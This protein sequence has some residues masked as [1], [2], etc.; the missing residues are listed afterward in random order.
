MGFFKAK[1]PIAPRVPAGPSAEEIRAQEEA[2]IRAENRKQLVVQESRRAKLRKS[3]TGGE[4]EDQVQRK[5]LF[6]E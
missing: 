1:I 4:D 2:K 6:G 5:R 3:L